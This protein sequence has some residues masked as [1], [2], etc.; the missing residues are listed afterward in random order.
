MVA[1]SDI[2]IIKVTM[3]TEASILS[4][5]ALQHPSKQWVDQYTCYLTILHDKTILDI[6]SIIIWFNTL[7]PSIIF[8]VHNIENFVCEAQVLLKIGLDINPL[9]SIQL[10][11]DVLIISDPWKVLTI[12]ANGPCHSATILQ[13]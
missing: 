1:T 6:Q 2:L 9:F 11:S 13:S 7:T 4:K 5:Q 12:D 3:T 10:C 8:H